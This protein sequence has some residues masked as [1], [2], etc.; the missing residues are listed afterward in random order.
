MGIARVPADSTP[1]VFEQSFE[2]P[3][4]VGWHNGPPSWLG[5]LVDQ[6]RGESG[7]IYLRNR[8]Y[9]S[10]TGRFT[11]EDPIGLAGGMNLYGFANGDPVN[12]SDPFGLCPKD[13][14]G[15]GKTDDYSDCAK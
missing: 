1:L 11:Q 4:V 13:A 12:Y 3:D 15:D 7:L 14:G 9:D 6:M 5:G 2:Y 8:Y 10:G